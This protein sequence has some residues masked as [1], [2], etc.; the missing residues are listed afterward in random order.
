MGN[1]EDKTSGI[2]K[3]L[4]KGTLFIKQQFLCSVIKYNYMDVGCSK[5]TIPGREVKKNSTFYLF[6][7]E[8]FFDIE[9]GFYFSF[10]ELL[11]II[12][13]L[14]KTIDDINSYDEL[15]FYIQKG[16]RGAKM[17]D[18][19]AIFRYECY[20]EKKT[21]GGEG[22][23][24]ITNKSKSK[25]KITNKSKSKEKKS[26]K[27][28]IKEKK[29]VQKCK[30]PKGHGNKN[31]KNNDESIC[32]TNKNF[33]K[34]E[35]LAYWI[36]TALKKIIK[37]IPSKYLDE[38]KLWPL[39][40]DSLK[41]LKELLG[42]KDLKYLLLEIID[43]FEDFIQTG[44]G[45]YGI[46]NAAE[47]FSESKVLGILYI[48]GGA[49]NVIGGGVDLFI[50]AN[51]AKDRR[52]KLKL[53]KHQQNFISLLNLMNSQMQK[54]M[55]TNYKDLYEN[56][57][58]ILSIDLED[59]LSNEGV[60]CKLVNISGIEEY[61]TPLNYS[62][63]NR[64]Q[65]I[66]NIIKFYSILLHNIQI[67]EINEIY[68]KG[69]NIDKYD[70]KD[71]EKS[72]YFLLYMKYIILN[73]Y[74][75]KNFWINATEYQIRN[76]INNNEINFNKILSLIATNEINED[77]IMKIY[78][79]EVETKQE[80][81]DIK[82]NWRKQYNNNYNIN[83]INDNNKYC[84]HVITKR[85]NYNEELNENLIQNNYDSNK[86]ESQQEKKIYKPYTYYSR[87]N[88]FNNSKYNVISNKKR[89]HHN[90]TEIKDFKNNS[91]NDGDFGAPPIAYFRKK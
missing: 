77:V 63:Y 10:L 57:V 29:F 27:S 56:N 67:P 84:R 85:R 45:I 89:T 23:E 4:N 74:N 43:V 75:N 34:H 14:G 6:N 17:L 52:K 68:D 46:V 7:I 25:E 50:K 15:E 11:R 21:G 47:I 82:S 19:L 83:K 65:Y 26:N 80:D 62:D 79:K 1:D 64:K 9:N 35:E 90:Y 2:E 39:L 30:S 70:I 60:D 61:A 69:K 13:A 31:K 66:K 32:N 48:I 5:V 59:V 91:F 37:F 53:N 20:L 87:E 76:L 12:I 3:L 51:N 86:T 40:R 24:K 73:Q 8:G 49:I 54:M 41:F 81:N 58:I 55:N 88:Q 28:I 78:S 16:I 22:E 36:T 44:F 42:F 18:D 38:D 33:Y 72:Y 71:I